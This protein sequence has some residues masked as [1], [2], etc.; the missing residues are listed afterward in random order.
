MVDK[1]KRSLEQLEPPNC[2]N[3]S[4]EMKWSRSALVDTTTIVHVFVC[5]GCSHTVETQSKISAMSIPPKKLSAPRHR[6]AA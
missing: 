4:S 3:C 1:L 5:P 2:P 6:H